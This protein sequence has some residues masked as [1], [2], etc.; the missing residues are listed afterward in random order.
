MQPPQPP[1]PAPASRARESA[2]TDV[3]FIYIKCSPD[4]V[5]ACVRAC[6][7]VYKVSLIAKRVC[8]PFVFIAQPVQLPPPPPPPQAPPPLA[9]LNRTPAARVSDSCS[10][11]APPPP[12]PHRQNFVRCKTECARAFHLI[13]RYIANL[14][15]CEVRFQGARPSGIRR[16][17][18]SR[19]YLPADAFL[20]SHKHTHAYGHAKVADKSATN[21]QT[22]KKNIRRRFIVLIKPSPPGAR[23]APV[24]ML[25]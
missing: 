24:M 8:A 5:R 23:L 16:A 17:S 25:S 1:A 15:W 3:Y 2:C 18:L 11:V 12:S 7:G 14:V 22:T 6:V 10:A 4:N 13:P 21:Q 19:D 9:F 20:Y